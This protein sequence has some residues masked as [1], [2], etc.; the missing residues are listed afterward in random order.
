MFNHLSYTCFLVIR[1]FFFG[2]E[3]VK[4]EHF[5]VA[6]TFVHLFF[7][8]RFV[9]PCYDIPAPPK[10]SSEKIRENC[11]MSW[12]ATVFLFRRFPCFHGLILYNLAT[13]KWRVFVGSFDLAGVQSERREPKAKEFMGRLYIYRLIYHKIKSHVGKYTS[14]DM[15]GIWEKTSI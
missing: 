11:F 6:V 10:L 3:A 7:R 15:D 13:Q 2:D 14:H 12:L 9:G 8:S 1:I 4:Q 5:M